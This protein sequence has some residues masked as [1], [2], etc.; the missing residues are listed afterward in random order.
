LASRFKSLLRRPAAPARPQYQYSPLNEGAQEIRLMTLFPGTVSS[1]IRVGLEIVTVTKDGAY[2]FE[3]LSYA[4]GSAE[5]PTEIFVGAS[6]YQ[7]LSITQNLAEALPYLR[8]EDRSRVFWIDAICVNQQDLKERSRQVERMADIFTKASRVVV[9]LGPESSDSSVAMDCFHTICENVEVNQATQ[10]IRSLSNKTHWEEARFRLPFSA[11]QYRSLYRLLQRSWFERLWIWQ[12]VRLGSR[13][14]IVKCGAKEILWRSMCTA[15]FCLYT[16]GKPPEL[17]GSELLSLEAR[18]NELCNGDRRGHFVHLIEQTQ[19]SLCS[20]PRDKVFAILSLLEPRCAEFLNIKPDYSK[21]VH[22][23]Y[24]KTAIRYFER[25]KRLELLQM[26][27]EHNQS[28]NLPSW[29]PDFRCPRLAISLN[30]PMMCAGRSGGVTKIVKKKRL[31]ITGLRIATI[32]RIEG[33]GNHQE[34][35]GYSAPGGDLK[36]IASALLGKES[37]T[38]DKQ[39]FQAFCRTI[40]LN[41]FCEMHDPPRTF[42]PSMKHCENVLSDVLNHGFSGDVLSDDRDHR[43]VWNRVVRSIQGRSVFKTV[44]GNFGLAPKAAMVGDAVVILLG[45]QSAMIFREGRNDTYQVI[46][47]AY[48]DGFME[49]QALLGPLP[50]PFEYIRHY[51]EPDDTWYDVCFNRKTGLVQVEDTRLGPLPEHVRTI[52]VLRILL[53]PRET[54]LTAADIVA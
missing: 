41:T 4:W 46:G 36:R 18:V 42:L 3:A 25:Y 43:K 7:V 45:C 21:S 29:V 10:V 11:A 22:E 24:T 35:S 33:F 12:D 52:P 34:P 47:E 17:L 31:R 9:W 19:R 20:D 51:N 26:V 48:L 15:V 2:D 53:F 38:Y 6:G 28:Q 27:E 37:Y 1:E 5:N 54:K 14:T 8:Y 13:N 32:E 44:E 40:C 50:D 23:V 39:H 30:G 16:K 49:C